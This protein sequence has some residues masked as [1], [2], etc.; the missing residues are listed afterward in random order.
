MYN[1]QLLSGITVF[2]ALMMSFPALANAE[3]ASTEAAAT[4]IVSTVGD[5]VELASF[6]GLDQGNH[7]S[8]PT[9]E[10]ASESKET[11][12][13]LPQSPVLDNTSAAPT[14]S[15]DAVVEIN[16]QAENAQI[17]SA[18]ADSRQ[19]ESTQAESTQTESTQAESIRIES[20]TSGGADPVSVNVEIRSSSTDSAVKGLTSTRVT[21]SFGSE[22][23]IRANASVVAA[24]AVNIAS[25]EEIGP[26]IKKKEEPVVVE[27]EYDKL[28]KDIVAFALQHVGLRYQWG[29]TNLSRAVDCSGL[30][31]EVYKRFGINI[32]RTSRDQARLGRAIPMNEIKPGDLLI[33]TD[34]T[35]YINHVTMYIGNNKLINGS[36][37]STGVIISD[38][39]YRT[40]LKAVRFIPD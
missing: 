26:G 21:T 32:G 31:S 5:R 12:G 16:I 33:Y 20:K 4:G 7:T 24:K 27:T 2:L 35:G 28:R 40:P 29:G 10:V 39:G 17:E 13:A 37:E 34:L 23:T 14:K 8:S 6:S 15:A 19:T 36:S 11:D 3:A 38:I 9:L 18:S 30:T 25:K 1:R 22:Q